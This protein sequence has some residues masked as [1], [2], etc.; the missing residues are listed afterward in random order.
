MSRRVGSAVAWIEPPG[1]A[2]ARHRAGQ[3]PDPVGGPDDKLRETPGRHCR[4]G[5]P[6]PDFAE[7][8]IG[9]AEGGTRWLNPGHGPCGG[10]PWRA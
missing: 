1:P 3:R 4:V 8:I 2:G 9:P 5:R 6:F 7:F 10:N